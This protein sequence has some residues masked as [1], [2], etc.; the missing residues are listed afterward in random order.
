MK[1]KIIPIVIA[2]VLIII[3][4]GVTFGSRI[5]EKYSYS[6]ERADLNVYYGITGS[7][8]AAIVLQDEIVEE[9]ARISD[10]IC[11]LDMATIH[12]YL[13]DR[14][15]VDGGEGLLLYTLPEDIVRNS[16]GSSVKETAQGSE[17]LGYTAAIWEGD[18][19]YVALDYIKQYT[20]FSYQLFTDPYRIQLTTEWPS[21]EVASI[22]KNTQVRVKGGVK[23]EILTD[24]QKGDQVSVLEQMETWSKVKT[25]DSVIGYV[26]NKRLTG[27]RS[28]QPIPVTDYQEPE[29]TSLTRDHKINLG[30]HVVASAGGN[31]TFNSVTANA[32]NLNV[33][34][35]T[36]F[37]LCDN[38]GGYTSF[39]SA[40][41][42][43]KAHDRGLE[44]WALIENIE[45]K[46]SI[47]MYEILSSTTTRQKLIDSLM[48][49][50]ITY[51]IDGINVDFEQLSM[52][53]G[54]HFVEFIRELS[55][56]CRKN[57]KVLSVDNYVPRD[58]NDYYDRKE[59]GI[60]A[61]YVIVMGYDEHYAGSK[62]AGSVASIDY[63][64]DGIA[65]TVK[66]VPAEKVINAIPFY[67]RIWETTGDGISSQAVDMVT[68]EQFISN[69]GITAEWDET[70][71]QNYGE[72]TSGDSRYQVWLE[73]ADSIKVKLNVMENYG[74]GGVAE[75]R[76]GFEKPEIW[77]VIGEY[78]DK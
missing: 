45:Y 47:S 33:I 20:N 69:H 24:V 65:Q 31:D 62:E 77:D 46:D 67:T 55:V 9:K 17:E 54:E 16:I 72:Y 56:A 75:W 43:Q 64:E 74:I 70:T 63:V 8:E 59:Q 6:K 28:E 57:G 10:G 18:T 52:D 21:Y 13:N 25:A 78:L 4:G 27:I 32:G 50:L 30:W 42:V 29:Y 38:E 76:L 58:F 15:Y 40:D 73:D 12:K 53:C 60:V 66:E 51:G 1:K 37:K 7:Q 26:E 2:I 41:Y 44:V 71:C 3:I 34:S 23:S 36:W 5:L 49:D 48:N 14:F 19:L 61:D 11:Y 39:A 22:S 35:P 68:A